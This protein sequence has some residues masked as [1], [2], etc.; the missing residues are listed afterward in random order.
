MI[1]RKG[2]SPNIVERELGIGEC[3]FNPK[4]TSRP[5]LCVSNLALPPSA[6]YLQFSSGRLLF[7]THSLGADLVPHFFLN[8]DTLF[9]STHQQFTSPSYQ[10]ATAVGVATVNDI[11]IE[12]TAAL[13]A[14]PLQKLEG[15]GGRDNK[16]THT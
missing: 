6:R 16:R 8:V 1:N 12:A 7:D 4:S 2:I 13:T 11:P 15:G 3:Y 5:A 9:A 10:A 14:D